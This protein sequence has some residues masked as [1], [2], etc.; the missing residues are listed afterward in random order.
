[1]SE[2]NQN[3]SLDDS[4]DEV[5][6]TRSGLDRLTDET[7]AAK[8]LL[9]QITSKLPLCSEDLALSNSIER[10]EYSIKHTLK[11]IKE[12]NIWTNPRTSAK[13]VLF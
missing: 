13:S 1:M 2:L 4:R 5:N 9:I 8:K 11:K 10:L 7:E 12:I 3:M 6:Y